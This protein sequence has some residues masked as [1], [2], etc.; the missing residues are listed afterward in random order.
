VKTDRVAAWLVLLSAG[1]TMASFNIWHALHTGMT[2][3]LAWLVGVIIVVIVMGVSHVAA[4]GTSR[5]DQAVT[6]GVMIGA[7][8]LSVR[9]TGDVVRPAFGPLWWLFGLTVDAAA[10]ICLRVILTPRPAPAASI[11]A[12]VTP[13]VTPETTG[14]SQPGPVRVS[15]AVSAHVSDDADARAARADYRKSLKGP[16]KPLSQRALGAKYDK[17]QT[18]GKA[19]I[20]E[21]NAGPAPVAAAQ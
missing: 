5:T 20:A 3:G 18:W 19:R 6:F 8:V 9:A 17:S 2:G 11:T 4:S 12:D 21:V 16:G 15:A 13:D 14:V 1:G 7:M 10:L